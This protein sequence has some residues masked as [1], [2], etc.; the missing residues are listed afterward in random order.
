[1]NEQIATCI[2]A[3]SVHIL[4]SLYHTNILQF[5]EYFGLTPR[6]AFAMYSSDKDSFSSTEE[7]AMKRAFWKVIGDAASLPVSRT[8][9]GCDASSISDE[10]KRM[11]EESAANECEALEAIFEEGEFSI[12][13]DDTSTSVTIALPFGDADDETKL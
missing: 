4:I 7:L 9:F 13:K 10:D 12:K 8:C 1:M 5:A 3:I 6:E 11:N 2:D